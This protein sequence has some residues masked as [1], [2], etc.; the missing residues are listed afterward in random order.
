[1][2][3]LTAQ[4]I[5]KETPGVRLDSWIHENVMTVP[6]LFA[7][8]EVGGP[9]VN[10]PEG[11]EA[12]IAI[13]DRALADEAPKYSTD[14]ANAWKI[15]ETMNSRGWPFCIRLNKDGRVMAET[16][17]VEC[18]SSSFFNDGQYYETVPEAICKAALLGMIQKPIEN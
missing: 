11:H 15:V 4:M 9:T 18:N 17:S 6:P 3:N 10:Y 14:I 7:Y 1:M 16:G 2:E 13:S 12:R 5:A 8:T